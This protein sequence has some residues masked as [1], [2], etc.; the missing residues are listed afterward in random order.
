MATKR[1]GRFE[2]R[3]D[4][5]DRNWKETT[6]TLFNGAIKEQMLNLLRGVKGIQGDRAIRIYV[7]D[8]EE[9]T[10]HSEHEY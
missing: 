1:K 9:G 7:Y 10:K 5:Y 6:K 4:Y 3:L 8:T 2:I